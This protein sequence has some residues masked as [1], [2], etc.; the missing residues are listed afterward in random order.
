MSAYHQ[1]AECH[2][3]EE[4]WVALRE[5]IAPEHHLQLTNKFYP[6]RHVETGQ[7]KIVFRRKGGHRLF[8]AR[9]L[10]EELYVAEGVRV[11]PEDVEGPV[12]PLEDDLLPTSKFDSE[13][14]RQFIRTA[15]VII[16]KY[17]ETIMR[18]HAGLCGIFPMNRYPDNGELVAGPVLALVAERRDYL[19]E[20]DKPLPSHIEGVPLCTIPGE[21]RPLRQLVRE[22]PDGST[23][24]LDKDDEWVSV[25]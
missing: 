13:D 24:Y 21:L 8:M 22:D 20:H 15:S 10:E 12:E 4:V 11:L 9:L 5:L 17:A 1:W 18:E 3:E 23:K 14:D 19:T 2:G 7:R 6:A 16:I 25:E